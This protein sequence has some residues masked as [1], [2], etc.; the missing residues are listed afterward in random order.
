[1]QVGTKD[2]PKT[3]TTPLVQCCEVALAGHTLRIHGYIYTP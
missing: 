1:M 3:G 2:L